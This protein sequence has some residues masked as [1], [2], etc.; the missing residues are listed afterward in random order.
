M[1]KQK[2]IYVHAAAG[3]VP[4]GVDRLQSL[5]ADPDVDLRA[6]ARRVLGQNLRQ[7]SHFVELAAIGA[8]LCF[9]RLPTP[10]APDM[11]VYVGTALGEIRRTDSLSRQMLP[12]GPGIAT[13]FDF[14]N[15][16]ANMAAF[17]VAR[18]AGVSA[19]NLTVTQGVFSF[20]TALQLAIS[21]LGAGAVTAALVGGVDENCF[22]RP[23]YLHRWPLRDDE[24]MG[25]GS[26]WLYLSTQPDAAIA[27]LLWAQSLV[28]IPQQDLSLWTQTLEKVLVMPADATFTFVGGIGVTTSERAALMQRFPQAQWSSYVD[29][30]GSYPTAAAYGVASTVARSL[31]PGQWVHVNRDADGATMVIRWCVAPTAPRADS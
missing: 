29:Y 24:F 27:E 17:Y 15:A 14:I 20:E 23:Q 31:A 3:F 12:P 19:R 25:E 10:P 9:D 11:A 6:L 18:L 8:R 26:A 22:P 16:S 5:T 21:D 4:H 13:P 7:A 1:D 28:A 30:C 2:R